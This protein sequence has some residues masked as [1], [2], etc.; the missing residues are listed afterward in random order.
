MEDNV[1][2][3]MRVGWYTLIRIQLETDRSR[4]PLFEYLGVWCPFE[5]THCR[6]FY[7]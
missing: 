2:L 1:R 3:G 7:H 5:I 6:Y 4:L